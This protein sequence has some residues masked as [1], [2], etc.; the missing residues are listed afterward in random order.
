M[1]YLAS[2]VE[3]GPAFGRLLDRYDVLLL[4]V[5]PYATP[6]ANGVCSVV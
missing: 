5:V 2:N 1:R 3:I 6:A 4:P